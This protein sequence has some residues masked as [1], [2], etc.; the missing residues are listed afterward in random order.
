MNAP[1]PEPRSGS[2]DFQAVFVE[3]GA[4]VW[5][6]LTRLGVPD[7]DAPDV[8]QEVFLIVH[9]RLSEFDP[10]R[11]SLRTWLYGICLKVASTHRRRNPTRRDAPEELLRD[12]P[13]AAQPDLDLEARRAWQ[14]LSLVLDEMDTAKR[15]VFVLY[16]L[17]A[18]S[19]NEIA[20]ILSCPLQTAYARLHAARR[21]VLSAFQDEETR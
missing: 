21:R 19:M 7:R 12:L 1:K 10:D 3:H 20:A 14:R 2:P 18:L 5:R 4:F 9:R 13:A 11:G 15:E 16:E 8:C 17:E 6:V